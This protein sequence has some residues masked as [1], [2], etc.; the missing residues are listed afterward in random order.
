MITLK[1]IKATK[2]KQK[3][4]QICNEVV[5]WYAISRDGL[6]MINFPNGENKFYTEAG[7]VRRLNKLLNT[8]G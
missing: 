4:F 1:D 6:N 5:G 3:A 2:A 7:F 8:G